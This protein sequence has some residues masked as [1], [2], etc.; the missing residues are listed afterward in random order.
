MWTIFKLT[1]LTLLFV[2]TY[3]WISTFIP[4]PVWLVGLNFLLFVEFSFLP[5]PF[6]LDKV[7]GKVI[8]AIIAI[9]AWGCWTEGFSLGIWNFLMYFPALYLLSLPVG[10]QSDLLRFVTKWYSVLLIP[11]FILYVANIVASTPMM[12]EF[13]YGLYPPFENYIFYIKN[14]EWT[15]MFQRFNAFFLEP[16]H[17]AL[18]STF[19]LIANRYDFKKVPWLWILV[20]AVAF[21]FSLAGYMLVFVGFM[22]LKVNSLSR[23]LALVSIALAFFIGVQAWSGGDNPVNELILNRLEYD[24]SKGIKGN[25]RFYGNTDKE[26]NKATKNGDLLVGVVGK[27][28]MDLIGG[29]GYKI[30]ILKYGIIGAVLALLFYLSLIPPRPDIRYTASFLIVFILCF[31]QRAYP[32]WYSWILP[33]IL[34]IYIAADSAHSIPR[35]IR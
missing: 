15:G 24:E 19:L 35:Q 6:N 10:Y 14:T 9:T 5:V 3:V 25:N 30:F 29:A 31:F 34:G 7:H 18:F 26:F 4:M 13:N 32:Y 20:I 17:Q 23:I 27:A 1:N 22:L 11:A 21:S 16:G 8:M 33:Y 28:R 12:G 2:S